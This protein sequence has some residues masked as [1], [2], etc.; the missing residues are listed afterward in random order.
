MVP[1]CASRIWRTRY[2]PSPS[3]PKLRAETARSKRAKIL[4]WA[5]GGMPMPRSRTSS[6]ADDAGDALHLQAER[7]E[8][9]LELVRCDRQELV[10]HAHGVFDAQA[11]LHL[12]GD[13][14]RVHHHAVSV[15]GALAH[16]V[17]VQRL[18]AALV[19]EAQ[20]ELL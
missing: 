14:G 8:R 1:P 7:G 20:L 11:G 2:S 3:P 12:F 10:A 16:E 4:D 17:E 18:L 9:G 13:V 5:S 15:R 19:V 6:F